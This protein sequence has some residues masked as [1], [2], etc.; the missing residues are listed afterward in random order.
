[1][2]DGVERE[3]LKVLH[4][5]LCLTQHGNSCTNKGY[6]SL[7]TA[8]ASADASWPLLHPVNRKKAYGYSK[9]KEL[10]ASSNAISHSSETAHRF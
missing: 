3:L 4:S 8:S 6:A 5:S 1:M 2:C 7:L 10:R 9:R